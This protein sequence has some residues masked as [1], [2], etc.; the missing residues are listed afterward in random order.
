M[1]S[2][3][4]AVAA[5]TELCGDGRTSGT[6]MLGEGTLGGKESQSGRWDCCS[7][8][9]CCCCHSGSDPKPNFWKAPLDSG[10]VGFWKA[11]SGSGYVAC[12]GRD[13][14]PAALLPMLRL[15][16]SLLLRLLWLLALRLLWL[17]LLRVLWSLRPLL[18]VRVPL[19][20]STPWLLEMACA[21]LGKPPAALL[22][23]LRLLWSL[24]PLLL[25]RAPLPGFT[26]WL[27]P[28]PLLL[29]L[30]ELVSAPP[31][32]PASAHDVSKVGMTI[33]GDVCKYQVSS[34]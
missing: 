29:L 21:E 27:L 23:L 14:P 8:G 30:A 17:L 13:E 9:C 25:V 20:G 28:T 34:E 19:P 12:E 18:L 5:A 7:C 10:C 16:W 15:R 2:I 33:L 1:C 6:G 24:R 32:T 11:P 3:W 31:S 26:P 4:R 22:L